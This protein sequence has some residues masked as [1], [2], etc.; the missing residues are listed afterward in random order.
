MIPALL[1]LIAPATAAGLDVFDESAFMEA[2]RRGRV[3]GSTGPFVLARLDETEIG[4]LHSGP[5]GTLYVKVAAA[6]WIPVSEWRAY[7]NGQE[8]YRAKIEAGGEAFLPLAFDGDSFVTVEVEGEAKGLYRDA[9]PGFTPFAFTNPIF[10]DADGH[11]RFAAP[12]LPETLPKT[13]TDPNGAD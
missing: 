3:T 10:V 5:R 6:P 1:S 8:V 2:L 9:L 4:D 7:V 11:G 13:L 12:G